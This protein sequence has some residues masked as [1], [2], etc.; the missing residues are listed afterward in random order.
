MMT[1]NP[2]LSLLLFVSLLGVGIGIFRK[3]K[4]ASGGK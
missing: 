2:L 3:I 4:G 1:S